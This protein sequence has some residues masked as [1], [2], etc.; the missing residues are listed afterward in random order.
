MEL[1][2]DEVVEH[3]NVSPGSNSLISFFL[4]LTFD[5]DKQ[6]KAGDSS[7]GLDGV[8]NRAYTSALIRFGMSYK[9][10]L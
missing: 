8:G 2:T 4:R 6:G 7:N 1:F 10:D 3:D 9:A 5:V